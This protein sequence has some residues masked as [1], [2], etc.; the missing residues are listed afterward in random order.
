M[1]WFD[2]L[3]GYAN[4]GVDA[5]ATIRGSKPSPLPTPPAPTAS[6][7]PTWLMPALIGG[8]LLVLVL[9]LVGFSRK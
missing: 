1:S 9:V 3:V 7:S 8:G 4:E 5:Y 6:T 2:S